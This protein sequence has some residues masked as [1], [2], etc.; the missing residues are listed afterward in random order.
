MKRGLS[1]S[2]LIMFI[3]SI[4]LAS[5][6]KN[7]F[8]EHKTIYGEATINN[9]VLS[10]YTTIGE[11]VSNKYWFLPLGVVN[12]FVIKEG[13]CYLQLHLRD[14]KK[15]DEEKFWL[16]LIGCYVDKNFPIIGKEY[17]IVVQNQ[18][19]LGNISNSFYESGKLRDFYSDNFEFES[20]CIA[21][22]SIYPLHD[23][24]IPLDGSLQFLQGDSKVGEYTISYDLK[25]YDNSTNE[26]YSI[27]GRFT[28]KLK[29]IN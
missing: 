7:D 2:L 29:I 19:D 17:K 4:L 11:A 6:E 3:M 12:N 23:E 20:S 26:T 5:C 22:L 15:K 28:G 16:I 10:Q 14:C 13:V 8:L 24:F 27:K 9:M 18:I 21:G 25:S 1:I